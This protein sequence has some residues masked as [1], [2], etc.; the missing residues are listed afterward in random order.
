MTT[1]MVAKP[2]AND[3]LAQ[4]KGLAKPGNLAGMARFGMNPEGRL[5]LSVPEMRRIA[6]D[7]GR[8]HLLALGLWKSGIAEARIVASLVDEPERV[9]AAQMDRWVRAFDS[10]D[11]CDQTC[12]NLFDKTPFAWSKA[13]T[14]SRDKREYVKRAGFALMAYLAWHDKPAS[15]SAF[16][17]FFPSIRRGAT[18]DRNFVKK[19]VSWA[20]RTIGKRNHRLRSAALREA[21]ALRALDDKAARWVGADVERELAK[22]QPPRGAPRSAP[23]ASRIRR[24][25]S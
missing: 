21:R 6:K 24:N 23:T 12:G 8:D 17:S 5:G 9:T 18:D 1:K 19:A 10:W 15:D 25:V 20:L 22:R 4:L 7:A 13:R 11:V 14:W 16:L 2:S 3:V